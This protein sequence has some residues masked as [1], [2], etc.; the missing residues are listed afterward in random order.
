M[1]EIKVYNTLKREKQIFKPIEEG[2]VKIYVCGV[3]PYN[4]PHIGNARPAVTWDIIRR[5]LEYIG[6]HVDFIQNFTDVDDKI[7]NKANAE[8]SDWK[9]VSTRYIDAYFKV[10]DALHIRRADIYP[11]VSKHMGDIIDMVKTL[12]EKGHAYVLGNDVYY[13]IST[14]KDYCKLSGRK[15]EDMLAGARVMVNTSKRNPGDFAL[16]KGAKPGEPFWESPWGNGRP[17]WHIECSVMSTHYLGATFD[18]HGGGSDLIFPHHENEIAQS[19]GA[20]GQK[21]VKYWLHNGFITIN[22]EKMSK[23]LN[24][25]F[26]VK[27]VLEKYSG[28]A[29]RYF[30]LSTHYRSPLD[31][32]DERLEEAEKNMSKLKDVIARIKEMEKEEG[33]VETNE[34][35]SLKKA[36][37]RTIEEF[38]QAMN[39]D[40]NTGLATGVL[41]DFVK[42]INIYYNSVNSGVAIDKE[43]VIEAKET[44]KTILDILGILESEWNTQES[45]AGSDYDALMEMI[46]SVRETARKEKQYKLAELG[47]IV[48]DFATGARWK[49]RGV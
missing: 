28:D 25:F 33:K 5:Y 22:S 31:F 8:K 6:Y 14:F 23:S 44:F 13:D 9:T 21:F 39:D 1:E 35:V 41:F 46:L 43:A 15:V 17:G 30:L 34:S 3:T 48:E 10:M 32:S 12:I 7:I 4:H 27:D 49:K 26:L 24:N 40:F 45:Y 38:R 47:I 42:D 36:A 11:Y 29:L 19:E 16:W 18:F 2:K 37:A 20:T